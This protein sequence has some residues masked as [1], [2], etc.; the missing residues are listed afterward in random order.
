MKP[1]IK[2]FYDNG[3]STLTYIVY[4]SKSK[5][6]ILIDPVLNF[7]PHSGKISFESLDQVESFV[8]EKSLNLHYSLETHAHA[9]HLSGAHYLK[10]RFPKIKVGVGRTITKVQELFKGIFN[11]KE[12]K[13]DGSQFDLL[14]EDGEELKAGSLTLKTYY[15]PGHTP[16]CS[17]YLVGDALFAGDTLFMPDFG[18]ARVDFPAGSAHDLYN[19]IHNKLYKLPDDTR[20]FVGHDYQPGG[21][22]LKY[23]TTIGEEKEKNIQI[24]ASA[25]EEEYIKFRNDRDAQLDAPRLLLPSIQVNINGGKLPEADDNGTSYLRIPLK[26]EE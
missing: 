6:A 24:P 3:T 14:L 5:D 20:V 25:S 1:D 21:R 13:T 7:D 26:I 8:K 10:E 9:D 23:E 2:T 16:A 11:L 19:S 15:T 22:D 12:L 4:D 18:T 17:S